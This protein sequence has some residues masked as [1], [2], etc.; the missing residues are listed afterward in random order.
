MPCLIRPSRRVPVQCTLS[1]NAERLHSAAGV[2][3][4][5]PRIPHGQAPQMIGATESCWPNNWGRSYVFE[6]TSRFSGPAASELAAPFH[7]VMHGHIEQAPVRPPQMYLLPKM[8]YRFMRDCQLCAR[9][10]AAAL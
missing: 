8:P 3:A 4:T 7:L 1:C 2:P 9:S 10:D 6:Y 5:S